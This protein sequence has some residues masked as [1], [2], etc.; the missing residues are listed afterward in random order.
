D[1]AGLAVAFGWWS[2]NQHGSHFEAYQEG[3]AAAKAL[4]L[5][6]EAVAVARPDRTFNFFAHSLGSHVVLR[7]LAEAVEQESVVAD[8]LR[9]VV[10]I[11]GSEFSGVAFPIY[12]A[13]KE[14]GL[15]GPLTI[16][17][18][19]DAE[20]QV[21]QLISELAT[22]G[23][24]GTKHMICH[25][26][27]KPVGGEP[28]GNGQPGWI[29]LDLANPAFRNWAR[30]R[31]GVELRAELPGNLNHWVYFTDP[32]NT[33]F[34]KHLLRDGEGE[35]GLAALRGNGGIEGLA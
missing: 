35:V 29:D 21:T 13:L 17:N 20:D 22:Y 24:D 31:F 33:E 30:E 34:L 27:L 16:Y 9:R 12:N 23:P 5:C 6:V 2:K 1:P 15:L 3:L 19:A 25:H 10:L 32:G 18:V 28:L 4:L 8:R 26:G 14:K 11:V 7:C